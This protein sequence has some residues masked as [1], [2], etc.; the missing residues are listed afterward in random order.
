MI[1]YKGRPISY[2]V[3]EFVYHF[4]QLQLYTIHLISIRNIEV[5]SGDSSFMLFD[6]EDGYIKT[7]VHS[8]IV[9]Q[10]IVLYFPQILT[11]KC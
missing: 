11:K 4:E 10:N 7:S 2:I 3:D 1:A 9:C 5:D 6:Q 8:L